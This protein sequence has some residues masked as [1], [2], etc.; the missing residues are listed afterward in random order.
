MDQAIWATWYDLPEAGRDDYLD[1]LHGEYLPQMQARPGI[2]W[3]AHYRSDGGGADMQKVRD[4]FPK[5]VGM[6]GVGD[7]TQ[8]LMLIGAV[9]PWT[10]AAPSVIDEQAAL[11]NTTKSLNPWA[12]ALS[13]GL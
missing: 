12:L 9:E 11:V 1:W 3:A 8:F 5:S 4:T 10:L 13:S 6:E 7:G 2:A